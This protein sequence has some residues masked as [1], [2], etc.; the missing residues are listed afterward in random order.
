MIVHYIRHNDLAMQLRK[1]FRNQ[2]S[3]VDL[4]KNG[5]GEFGTGWHTDIP[6]LRAGHVGGQVCYDK[7]V[8]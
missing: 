5:S 6:R 3:E 1:D 4:T 2:L 7:Y 8:T